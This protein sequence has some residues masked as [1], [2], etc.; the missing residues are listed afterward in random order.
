VLSIKVRS[1]HRKSKYSKQKPAKA[2]TTSQQGIPIPMIELSDADF[3]INVL[4]TFHR[5]KKL[6]QTISAEIW[7]I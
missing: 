5:N 3:K 7:N 4:M 1:D 6:R 2:V